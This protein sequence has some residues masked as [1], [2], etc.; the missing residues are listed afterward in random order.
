MTFFNLLKLDLNSRAATC[1][2]NRVFG[3]VNEAG[4]KFTFQSE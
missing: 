2:R 4:E 1:W 3:G